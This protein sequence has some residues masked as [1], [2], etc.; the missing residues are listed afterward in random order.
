MT[1]RNSEHD[2]MASEESVE[3]PQL[4]LTLLSDRL[5]ICQL[6]R[7]APF[8]TWAC[9]GNFYSLTLTPNELSIVCSEEN[10]PADVACDAGWR[11]LS[12][13]GP[14]G[15]TLTGLVESLAEP[16][17]LAGISIFVVSTYTT[18]YLMVKQNDLNIAIVTLKTA[19]H[20]VQM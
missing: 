10:V 3:R 11:V 12:S 6:R 19:G 18:D 9:R 5:A 2:I 20:V 15:F 7:D 8:P 13:P 4:T 1:T 17:A 16:L 14:L